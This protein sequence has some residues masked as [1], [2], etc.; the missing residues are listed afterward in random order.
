MQ[1]AKIQLSGI[2]GIIDVVFFTTITILL[3]LLS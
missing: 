2:E 3:E 1:H